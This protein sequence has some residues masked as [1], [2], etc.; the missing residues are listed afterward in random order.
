MSDEVDDAGWRWC[1]CKYSPEDPCPIDDWA[2]PAPDRLKGRINAL[3]TSLA[4]VME[5]TRWLQGRNHALHTQLNLAVETIKELERMSASDNWPRGEFEIW[6]I[7]SG[8]LKRFS[9]ADS[10]PKPANDESEGG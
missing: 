5:R 6:E 2:E 9:S 10:Y 3:E 1:T 7:A 4:G 8:F